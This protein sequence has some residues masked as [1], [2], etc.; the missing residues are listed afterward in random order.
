MDDYGDYDYGDHET[1]DTE[2]RNIEF[3]RQELR[4]RL[5]AYLREHHPDLL[6]ELT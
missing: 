3:S 4:Q 2:T 1:D 5:V 6:E